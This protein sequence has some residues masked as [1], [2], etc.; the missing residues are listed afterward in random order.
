MSV[1][2]HEETIEI[3]TYQW[4]PEDPNPPFQRTGY[5][6]IY[7]YTMMDDIGDR[8]KP[9]IGKVARVKVQRHRMSLAGS[10]LLTMS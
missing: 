7:P 1:S 3:P 5:W 6:D 2:G 4:G 10:H 9:G 8:A